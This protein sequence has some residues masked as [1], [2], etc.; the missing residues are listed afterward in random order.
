V[1]LT[2]LAF[3]L[4]ADNPVTN[5]WAW[6]AG[7]IAAASLAMGKFAVPRYTYDR[8]RDRADKLE[9]EVARLNLDIQK[10]AVPALFAS[11]KAVEEAMTFMREVQEE[12]RVRER[13]ERER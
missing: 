8:E 5:P 10:E 12:R 9:A 13:I 3:L 4:A 2:L 7:G 11:S 1:L 6:G